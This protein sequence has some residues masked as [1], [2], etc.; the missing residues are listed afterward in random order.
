[1]YRLSTAIFAFEERGAG[2]KDYGAKVSDAFAK[3]ATNPDLYLV[4]RQDLKKPWMK[5]D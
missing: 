4:D 1:M 3:L 2:V 5:M